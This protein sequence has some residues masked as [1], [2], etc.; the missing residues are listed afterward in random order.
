MVE[1]M[2]DPAERAAVLEIAKAFMNLADHA[3]D[4]DDHGTPHRASQY[5]SERH[6]ADA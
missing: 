2:R 1:R 4:R 6:A 5:H 3:A